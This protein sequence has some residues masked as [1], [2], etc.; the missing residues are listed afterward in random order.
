MPEHSDD[1]D[2]LLESIADGGSVDVYET[3][4]VGA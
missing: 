4:D 2:R 3:I 1:L